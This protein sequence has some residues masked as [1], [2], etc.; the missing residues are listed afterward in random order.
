MSNADDVK[1]R[2]IHTNPY[3]TVLS[4]NLTQDV[5]FLEILS[6]TINQKDLY[7]LH[8]SNYGMLVGRVL[9][10][11]SFGIPNCK[12]SIF[13]ALDDNDEN[14]VEIFN[15]YPYTNVNSYDSNGIRYNLLPDENT[16]DECY[17]VVGT[18]PNKRLMLDNN[19]VLEIFDKYWKYTTV[20]NECGD[21]FIASVP[22]GNNTVHIDFDISDIGILSQRPRDM[23]YKG[24]NITQFENANQF[25]ESTNLNGLSQIYSQNQVVYVYPFCGEE[26]LNDIAITR[27]D[28]QVQYKFEPTCVFM[29]AVVTDT[30]S[31]SIGHNCKPFRTSGYNK[32]LVTGE[33]TIEMIRKTLDNLTEEFQIQGNRL[34]DGD[35]VWCYQIPMNLDYVK[36]D[37]YG[38]VVPTDNPEKGIPTRTRVRFRVSL[39]ESENDGIS[40][41]RA[42]YLIPNNPTLEETE[43]VKLDKSDDKTLDDYYEFGS[44][45]DEGSY[46]DLYWNNVYS[47]KNYIPRLQ[48]SKKA[49]SQNYTGIRTTNYSDAKNPAPFNKI[50]FR[51][52]FAYRLSCI[53]ATIVLLVINFIN[54]TVI[55][56]W[57]WVMDKFC[58][59]KVWPIKY[60]FNWACKLMIECVEFPFVSDTDEGDCEVKCYFPGCSNSASKKATKK[61]NPDCDSIEDNKDDMIQKVHQLLAEENEAVN[62]DFYNDWL[63]GSLY[64]PLWYWKK[65]RKKTYFFKLISRRAVN[66]FCN[67]D[68]KKKLNLFYPCTF[69]YNT[70]NFK[71]TFDKKYENR[72]HDKSISRIEVDRGMIREQTVLNGLKAYYYSCGVEGANDVFYRF[73]ATDIILL[74]S[75][76]SCDL[77]GIPQLFKNLPSTTN[78]TMPVNR[79][80][81]VPCG[82]EEDSSVMQEITG[83]DFFTS[84]ELQSLATYGNGYFMDIGC[85]TLHSLPKTCINAERLSELG[86]ALDMSY[87]NLN[88]DGNGLSEIQVNA[89]GMITRV[90]IEDNESR[91]MFATLN[92]NGL[93]VLKYNNNLGY[94]YYSFKY[95]YPIDF[96]GRMSEFSVSYTGNLS[97]KTYDYQNA[98]YL[99]FRQGEIKHFYNSSFPLYNNSFY[100]YFGLN[101]GNTAID[102]FNKLYFAQCAKNKQ[103]PFNVKIVTKPAAW[104]PLTQGCNYDRNK[105]GHIKITF[106]NIATPYFYTIE[107]SMGK[108][109]I[110]NKESSELEIKFDKGY[111]GEE[112]DENAIINDIYTL[113]IIDNNNEMLTQIINLSQQ[114]IS[115]DYQVKNLSKKYF[116]D[117]KKEEF[118]GKYNG[119]IIIGNVYIDN[120]SYEID[121]VT[122]N[123]NS[124]MLLLTSGTLNAKAKLSINSM[125][126]LT[127]FFC[128][129]DTNKKS[130]GIW[131]PGTYEL[132]IEQVVDGINTSTCEKYT[133]N[134]STSIVQVLNGKNFD[135]IANN[136]YLRFVLG[137]NYDNPNF[138]NGQQN[139]EKVK[140]SWVRAYNPSTYK[141]SDF[142]TEST[143][144][145]AVINSFI[146]NVEYWEDVIEINTI[147]IKSKD[148]SAITEGLKKVRGYMV[149][150]CLN[151][152][153]GVYVEADN[154][155]EMNIG[156]RG[157]VAPI[158]YKSYELPS[159]GISVVEDLGESINTDYIGKYYGNVTVTIPEYIFDE[160]SGY[161]FNNALP[162]YIGNNYTIY[163]N[164]Q[165]NNAQT[166]FNPLF[167]GKNWTYFAI[168]DNNGNGVY[169][170]P[171]YIEDVTSTNYRK[172][173]AISSVDKRLDFKIPLLVT[174]I[175]TQS[176]IYANIF[177][178][179]DGY[180]ELNIINGIAMKYKNINGNLYVYNGGNNEYEYYD[181]NGV[182]K[183]NDNQ[184]IPPKFAIAKINGRNV[185][186]AMQGMSTNED[187][188]LMEDR[189]KNNYPTIDKYISH[190]IKGNDK[191]TFVI[192]ACS[193]NNSIVVESN[194]VIQAIVNS[195]DSLD[196]TIQIQKNVICSNVSLKYDGGGSSNNF[197]FSSSLISISSI[198]IF[199]DTDLIQEHV[200]L[201][202]IPR[203]IR[204]DGGEDENALL[205]KYNNNSTEVS[206]TVPSNLSI[207]S[208]YL[209]FGNIPCYDGNVNYPLCT[210]SANNI[211]L[212]G[213]NFACVCLY[214][215]MLP[216]NFLSKTGLILNVN[217]MYDV[218]PFEVS[219]TDFSYDEIY[220][221]LTFSIGGDN[222][223]LKYINSITMKAVG[224][225]FNGSY[226]SG[227]CIFT[228]IPNASFKVN[229]SVSFNI[230]LSNNI[231]T[232]ETS[233]VSLD[234]EY[235]EEETEEGS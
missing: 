120:V 234:V 24:Y 230:T 149:Q 194:G 198:N 15:L 55:A 37:E 30:Y 184:S 153:K 154:T 135:M 17:A 223:N 182:V 31:T 106:D 140:E 146:E 1:K 77:N 5:D 95:L 156:H 4:V 47:V 22:V 82:T 52:T 224:K 127:E 38:N 178:W 211:G 115:I 43:N 203:I 216:S 26:D 51:L 209:Y 41:H 56:M 99:L 122:G 125:E 116:S 173:F 7:K 227:S 141:F 92:H 191:F 46:R 58:S 143:N 86:V 215:E 170:R 88:A 11:D 130:F 35:G 105:L 79:D 19:T 164:G 50:R 83:M 29:G 3:D 142:I 190:K 196:E 221:T 70:S 60:V 85:S 166:G 67:C 172:Y 186:Y 231:Y 8:T 76:N 188:F 171:P 199:V 102:K 20:T 44:A 158:L 139:Y 62:L 205:S 23:I 193:Y 75:L 89:D 109:I 131:K 21:Y 210:Y 167:N 42:K 80:V 14:N 201:S 218:R 202:Q 129:Y 183:L 110:D 162:N 119:E 232:I 148:E 207:R 212:S 179:C 74:G 226:S 36:M 18:F 124:Y 33:G 144:N 222:E 200:V 54:A 159:D 45:T 78:N 53:I 91:A 185:N 181:N 28:I 97:P 134:I 49:S 34:I 100:F 59:I 64:M 113:T 217:N 16:L 150:T 6:L 81:E 213:C 71:P 66:E 72:W 93:D 175:T 138:A 177:N 204:L 192:E 229:S 168:Y 68:K 132:I 48:V 123:G 152:S 151:L 118:C 235:K 94:Y 228:N 39:Q 169:R 197:I 208:P 61:K 161:I 145:E 2:R 165:W 187:I 104:I 32:S 10:N 98:S 12:V 176:N 107:N 103:Y 112:K 87:T 147:A 180:V 40:R 163:N 121:N 137:K 128:G 27:C 206:V 9:A 195:G 220:T 117:S 214:K 126:G 225:T 111:F 25:K 189:A 233:T 155:I 57:N 160:S 157:G 219:L 65:R 96:D 84:S 90:E 63:N 133:P 13:V 69:V 114:P 101:E 136:I 73:F 108:K 174:P